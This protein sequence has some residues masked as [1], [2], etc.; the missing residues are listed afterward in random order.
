[1]NPIHQT[2]LCSA[3]RGKNERG[4]IHGWHPY[5][6]GYSE[7]FVESAL[8][9]LECDK[10]TVVLDPWCGSGTTNIVSARSGIPSIGMEIN[11]V[12]SIF[13]AAKT[14]QTLLFTNEIDQ[15]FAT[16]DQLIKK[17]RNIKPQENSALLNFFTPSTAEIIQAILNGNPFTS[18]F[19]KQNGSKKNWR[20]ELTIDAQDKVLNAPYSYVI[21]VVF[22][23]IREFFSSKKSSNPTWSKSSSQIKSIKK[24]LLI[25]AIIKNHK[26]MIVDL[27]TF[28]PNEVQ[29]QKTLICYTDSRDSSIKSNSI[30]RV[31]TS[32]PYLTRIDYAVSTS[33]EMSLLGDYAFLS[34]IRENTMGA[35]VITKSIKEQ[36]SKW[37]V[38]CNNILVEVR[39]HKTKA[40]ESYYWK[41][42]VQYF[43]DAHRAICELHRVLKPSGRGLIVVQSSYFKDIEIPLGEIYVDML[44]ENGFNAFIAYRQEV[45]NHM[46]HVNTRSSI[47]KNGKVYFEDFVEFVKK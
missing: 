9:H 12:M 32:P 24:S 21:S 41:N 39:Q 28:Y 20:S 15:F 34:Y 14:P 5:Y 4:G 25:E 11:P 33:M 30:D 17:P 46:A 37:G 27:E 16:L 36:N 8:Q 22:A 26:K 44:K 2:K 42:M 6:A 13:A 7:A 38:L 31:I 10:G 29:K 43:S 35:P 3:K 1:M 18:K 23:T 47:Y 19:S 45:K 40:A